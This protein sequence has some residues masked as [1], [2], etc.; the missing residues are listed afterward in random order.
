MILD[1]TVRFL[2]NIS[3]WSSSCLTHMMWM[4]DCLISV[5]G[6]PY[7]TLHAQF[8]FSVNNFTNF[9][10]ILNSK[11]VVSA[12]T[13]QQLTFPRTNILWQKMG[14][15]TYNIW[16]EDHQSGITVSTWMKSYGEPFHQLCWMF[17]DPKRFASG[18]P[19]K[20]MPNIHLQKTPS[21]SLCLGHS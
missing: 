8:F 21:D 1:I 5:C 2:G 13:C 11:D 6:E 17:V 14:D 12:W 19:Y 15:A 10:T 16:V 7:G 3:S 4:F 20:S 9:T 18:A